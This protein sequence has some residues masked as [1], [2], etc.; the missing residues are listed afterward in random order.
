MAGL[1]LGRASMKAN[2]LDD[3][4]RPP[5]KSGQ[6]LPV[7][8]ETKILEG[9]EGLLGGHAVVQVFQ[10]PGE[11]AVLRTFFPTIWELSG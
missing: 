3:W 7:C 1:A 9:L 6:R 10:M 8:S 4:G 11:V 5:W 2:L